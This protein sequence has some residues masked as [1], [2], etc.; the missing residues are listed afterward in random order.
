MSGKLGQHTAKIHSTG[1]STL[2]L[3]VVNLNKSQTADISNV[4]VQSISSSE[5]VPVSQPLINS[6][7]QIKSLVT[8]EQLSDIKNL[9]YKNGEYIVGDIKNNDIY[10]EIIC[11]IQKQGY[12]FV[13][14]FLI[15]KKW[16]NAEDLYFSLTEYESS[17]YKYNKFI[18]E[19]FTVKK[20]VEG[21]YICRRAT[22][23]SN[24]TESY[25]RQTRARDEGETV[26]VKCTVCGENWKIGS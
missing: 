11:R 7:Y 1:T 14:D 21:L 16:D 8:Q 23:R 5:I 24:K 10:Y 13:Y 20:V 25:T 18:E 15:S 17:S 6:S 3:K 19:N 2:K 12:N 22:C 26:F 4:P 9:K